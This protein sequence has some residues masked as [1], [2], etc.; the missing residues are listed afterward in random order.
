MVRASVWRKKLA[1]VKGDVVY[2]HSLALPTVRALEQQCCCVVL[3][4]S[5]VSYSL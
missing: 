1:A 5:V 3:S 2:I 4:Y